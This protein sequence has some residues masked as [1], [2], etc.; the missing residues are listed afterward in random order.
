MKKI[1][2]LITFVMAA[3][4]FGCAEDD[5]NSALDSLEN[6][7][8]PSNL[9]A[10]FT[11]TQDNTGTVTILPKGEGAVTY[12][13]QYGDNSGESA[14]IRAGE[15]TTHVYS[16]GE[17]NVT[18]VGTAI[19]GK[20]TQV[21]LPLTVSLLPPTNVEAEVAVQTGNSMGITVSATAELE[22]Y[23][24]VTFGDDP[25]QVPVQFMEG[26]TITYQYDTVGT[27]TVTITAFS[28]ATTFTTVTETVTV[29]NPIVL[30]I[31]FEDT[32]LNFVFGDF[33]NA[34]TSIVDNP[35][36]TG[37]NTSSKVGKHVKTAGAETW[38]GTAIT[39]DGTLNLTSGNQFRVKVWSPAVGTVVKMKI[40]NLTDN[41]IAQEVDNVTT[42]ANQWEV[43]EYDFSTLNPA[44]SYSRIVLFFNF[45]VNGAG[46]SYYFDD[47]EQFSGVQV[48]PLNF[49][50]NFMYT[51]NNFGGAVGSEVANPDPSGINTSSFVGKVVKGGP[52][53]W[54]GV[55]VP[56]QSPIDF[57]SQQVVKMKVWSPA[58][59]IPV[60]MKFEN[61]N[62]HVQTQDIERTATTTVA[63][64]WEEL[65][66]D[67][68][69]INNANNYQQIVIFFNFGVAGTGQTYYFDDVKL[70][71]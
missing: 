23:F 46:E 25:N 62:P 59:G 14:V 20:T 53:T 55:A 13:V 41:T 38:A 60:L 51:W 29:T 47:I 66:Y 63:N 48:L 35:D 67:F 65:T 54:A 43:L 39:L 5:S 56:L 26:E 49:E 58:A 6:A 61:M 22:T 2:I 42:V 70:S 19:N 17:Y 45:N 32:T 68:T 50:S 12:E 64:Q 4:M 71:N 1:K 8:A 33:G 27:Y 36:A 34:T 28:G 24:E 7:A 40:E 31:N 21:S 57:S 37:I 69:G 18:I 16:Q 3:M 11:I 10:L 30:P 44:Q 15:T 9:S 52:E